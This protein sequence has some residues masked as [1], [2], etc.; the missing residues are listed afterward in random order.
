MGMLRG[1]IPIRARKNAGEVDEFEAT[2]P[3]RRVRNE[4]GEVA[5]LGETEPSF[6]RTGPLGPGHEATAPPLAVSI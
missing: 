2:Q 1:S 3:L 6:C 4:R 5:E